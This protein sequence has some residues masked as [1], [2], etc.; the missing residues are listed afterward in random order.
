MAES[1]DDILKSIRGIIKEEGYGKPV[2]C[3]QKKN[4]LPQYN[5]GDGRVRASSSF[6]DFVIFII[7]IWLGF[8]TYQQYQL[9]HIVN[10]DAYVKR[11]ESKVENDRAAR[12]SASSFI[13]SVQSAPEIRVANSESAFVE[14]PTFVKNLNVSG[15]DPKYIRL[16]MLLEV[17]SGQKDAVLALVPKVVA[18]YHL[19][20]GDLEIQDLRG[21][22][23]LYKFREQLLEKAQSIAGEGVV[24]DVLI[25]EVLI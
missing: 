9:M 22:A 18:D 13:A 20:L 4:D 19:L 21:S 16:K 10:V 11:V 1:I 7:L 12:A 17:Q 5:N 6:S 23:G 2:K 14:I 24:K 25:Q 8:L 3:S 15:D